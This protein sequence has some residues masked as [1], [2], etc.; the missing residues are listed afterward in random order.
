MKLVTKF[1]TTTATI[2][3]CGGKFIVM[4]NNKIIFTSV[5]KEMCVG[6]AINKH[7]IAKL[8]SKVT[9]FLVAVHKVEKELIYT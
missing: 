8:E 5:S 7:M 1:L 4:S 2:Y 9:E 6:I 3:Y